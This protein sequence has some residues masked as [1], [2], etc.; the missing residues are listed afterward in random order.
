[1]RT[2]ASFVACAVVLTL[3]VGLWF[4]YAP[5]PPQIICDCPCAESINASAL[6]GDSPEY[7]AQEHQRCVEQHQSQSE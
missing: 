6:H 2:A 3:A 4:A 1:M 5:Q 7:L